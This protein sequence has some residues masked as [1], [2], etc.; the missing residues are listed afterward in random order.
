MLGTL[1]HVQPRV[2]TLVR[3][4]VPPLE[5]KPYFTFSFLE[6]QLSEGLTLLVPFQLQGTP[7]LAGEGRRRRSRFE[8]LGVVPLSSRRLLFQISSPAVLPW[9]PC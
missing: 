4:L 2:P 3:A 7:P 8:G 5:F 6:S 1:M 9:R